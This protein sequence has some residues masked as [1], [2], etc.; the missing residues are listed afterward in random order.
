MYINSYGQKEKR[1]YTLATHPNVL[2]KSFLSVT[3]P[4]PPKKLFLT[5]TLKKCSAK[6]KLKKGC[7]H[8]CRIT[9]EI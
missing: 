5:H 1:L 4:S 2:L 9:P 6:K 3:P 7:Q 8:I